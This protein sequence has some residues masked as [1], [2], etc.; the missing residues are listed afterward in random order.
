[1]MYGGHVRI[2][3]WFC[4][5]CGPQL[6]AEISLHVGFGV[7]VVHSPSVHPL[8]LFVGGVHAYLSLMAM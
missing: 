5:A 8:P 2:Q 4:I 7:G 1:M 3:C 6:E